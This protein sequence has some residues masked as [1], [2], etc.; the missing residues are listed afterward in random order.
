MV[1][2]KK[3]NGEPEIVRFSLLSLL[4]RCGPKKIRV[5]IFLT[6]LETENPSLMIKNP[7]GVW[8]MKWSTHLLDLGV[9]RLSLAP[10][11]EIT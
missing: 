9:V 1:F 5:G 8:L 10:G 7:Q 6:S 11:I 4:K 3:H 2:P